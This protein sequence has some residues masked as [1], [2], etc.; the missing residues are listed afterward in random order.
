MG[1]ENFPAIGAVETFDV[2][3]LSRFAWLDVMKID[4]VLFAPSHEL[5]R[6]QLRA[7][8]NPDLT[9]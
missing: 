4:L 3:I 9:G 6:D 8:I 5:G 2:S 1:I 7:I